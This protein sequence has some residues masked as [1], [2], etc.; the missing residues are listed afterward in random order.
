M[1]VL[2]ID[3]EMT[4]LIK[5]KALL[6]AYGD[7]TCVTNGFQ[8][9]E[10]C[11]TAIKDGAPFDLITI[12]IELP[13]ASGFEVLSAINKF[14][15]DRNIPASIKIMVTASGTKSNLVKAATKGCNGFMVKPVRKD[16][17]DEKMASLGFAKKLES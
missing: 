6:G 10:Q 4:A 11:A 14:E 8:A 15:K 16:N 2:I 3:D 9:L 5:M 17:L 12:D 1:R 13:K 7:C